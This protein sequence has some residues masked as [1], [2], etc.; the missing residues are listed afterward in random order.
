VVRLN[1]SLPM[2]NINNPKLETEKGFQIPR[3]M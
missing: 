1:I 3:L 2:I